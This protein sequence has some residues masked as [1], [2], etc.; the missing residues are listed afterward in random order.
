M[1]LMKKIE[2][3]ILFIE[4]IKTQKKI[5]NQNINYIERKYELQ[6]FCSSFKSILFN[7]FLAFKISFQVLKYNLL[8]ISCFFWIFYRL[9]FFHFCRQCVFFSIVY[10]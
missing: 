8:T 5:M 10:V 4:T 9:H 6:C 2:M 3:F 1:S 7:K